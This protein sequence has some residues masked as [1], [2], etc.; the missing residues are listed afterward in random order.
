MDK[1]SLRSDE[2]KK[3]EMKY[4]SAAMKWYG[5][6]SPVGLGLFLVG[7]AATILIFSFAIS[8]LAN[9][10]KTGVEIREQEKML[11]QSGS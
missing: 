7:V 11:E 4:A 5:W 1:Q 10:G 2:L 3:E 9:T 8:V 6:G